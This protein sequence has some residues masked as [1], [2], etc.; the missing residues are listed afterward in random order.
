MHMEGGESL[1]PMGWTLINE[2]RKWEGAR[3]I[4]SLSSFL[5]ISYSRVWFLLASVLGEVLH[6]EWHTCWM[7]GCVPCL[8][9]AHCDPVTSV[10]IHCITLLT[11]FLALLLFF[12]CFPCFGLVPPGKQQQQKPFNLLI[13]VSGSV[14]WS[15]KVKTV[16]F[17][18][19]HILLLRV[20]VPLHRMEY[21]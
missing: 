5:P 21:K 19:H 9:V 17:I 20:G 3:Q 12:L 14:F 6:A 18:K 11:I 8:F 7:P 16:P 13:L 2:N 10:V 1:L 4:N 15:I